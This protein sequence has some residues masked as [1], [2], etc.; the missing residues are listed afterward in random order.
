MTTLHLQLWLTWNRLGSFI[1]KNLLYSAELF[2]KKT[3][4]VPAS[5]SLVDGDFLFMLR[6]LPSLTE[7][8]SSSLVSSLQVWEPCASSVLWPL[9]CHL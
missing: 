2:L 9:C 4:E 6:P 1:G 5:L 7:A 3:P 8:S